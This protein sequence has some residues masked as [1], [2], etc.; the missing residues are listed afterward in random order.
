MPFVLQNYAYR[1]IGLC[2]SFSII[3]LIL[4]HDYAYYSA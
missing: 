4:L 3:V 1:L 2:L